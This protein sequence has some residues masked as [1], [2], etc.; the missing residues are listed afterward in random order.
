MGN[1][2]KI[3]WVVSVHTTIGSN[4][5]HLRVAVSVKKI[6][7][8]CQNFPNPYILKLF[9]KLKENFFQNFLSQNCLL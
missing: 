6:C 7:F 1:L 8:K 9:Q 5:K 4:M 3:A 2:K